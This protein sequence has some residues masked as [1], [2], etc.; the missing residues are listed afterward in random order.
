M[1]WIN[2]IGVEY[3]EKQFIIKLCKAEY[4]CRLVLLANYYKKKLQFIENYS[5]K[6]ARNNINTCLFFRVSINLWGV[7][8]GHLIEFE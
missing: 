7:V 4:I 6:N 5:V 8:R 1:A 2:C 3:S